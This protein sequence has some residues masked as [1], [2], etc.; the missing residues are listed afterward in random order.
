MDD[1]IGDS[2]EL[3]EKTPSLKVFATLPVFAPRY[4]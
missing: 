4:C 1:L 2:V 3:L